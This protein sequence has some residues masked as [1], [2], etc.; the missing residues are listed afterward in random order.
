MGWLKDRVERTL[1]LGV[2]DEPRPVAVE[3]K[4][5]RVD[6]SVTSTPG[7]RVRLVRASPNGDV[8]RVLLWCLRRDIPVELV[9]DPTASAGSPIQLDGVAV[10][11]DEL[12]A[13]LG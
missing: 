7:A 1:G 13:R 11:A 9:D 10:T 12:R 6:R 2:A 3:A 5:K 8:Q 4:R